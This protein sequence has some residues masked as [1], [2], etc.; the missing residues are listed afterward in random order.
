MVLAHDASTK[1]ELGYSKIGCVDI[2]SN[3]F[4]GYGC[5]ILPNVHIGNKVIIGAGTIISKDIPDNVVV[6]GNP[7]RVICT[8]DEYMEKNKQ[9]IENF[10]VSDKYFYEKSEEEWDELYNKVKKYNGGYDL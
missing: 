8:Y 10:N 4:I 6:V 2:G 9:K 5:I 1:K 7:N 3:V